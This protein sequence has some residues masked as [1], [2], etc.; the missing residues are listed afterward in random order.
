VYWQIN[1]WS[2]GVAQDSCIFGG[3]TFY[4]QVNIIMNFVFCFTNAIT[5]IIIS[6]LKEAINNMQERNETIP[7]G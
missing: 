5:N 3:Q 2:S 6:K 1:D 4:F 7:L